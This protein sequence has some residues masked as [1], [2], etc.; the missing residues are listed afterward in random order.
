MR[1]AHTDA[2]SARERWNARYGERAF[3]PFPPTPGAWLVEHRDLLDEVSGASGTRR[4]LD[5]ACGDGRD[6]RYLAELGFEVDAL[7]VS[8]IAVAAL[9]AAAIARG[10]TVDAR[11]HDLEREP[12]ATA[13]YDVVVCMNYLQRDLFAA[14]RD[15]LAP[16]G[17]LFYETFA[18]AHVEELG[19]RFNPAFVL[20][21]N[22]LL[23]TF[24]ELYVLRYREGPAQR[25]GELRGVA[26]IVAQRR[27][28]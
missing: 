13:A 6:A 8:D 28:A 17:L 26:S 12:L 23:S 18:R 10:L 1:M 15:A 11:V 24:S 4:A 25:R 20:D 16:G 5:V 2:T 19:R 14:L 7:D 3:E 21:R 27:V 9:R 22:E